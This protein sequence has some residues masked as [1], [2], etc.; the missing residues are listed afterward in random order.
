[1]PKINELGKTVMLKICPQAYQASAAV[2][3]TFELVTLKSIG[4]F[5]YW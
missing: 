5:L 2:T 4:I 1:M 3:L